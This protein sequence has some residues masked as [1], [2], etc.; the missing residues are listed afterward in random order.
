MNLPRPRL[1]GSRCLLPALLLALTSAAGQR[2][3]MPACAETTSPTQGANH[4]WVTTVEDQGEG[5]LRQA[6]EI[7]NARPGADLIRFD[8][9]L[10]PFATH[11]T[12]TLK[13]PLPTLADD[14]TI[15]GDQPERLWQST[16][17]TLSGGN[18]LPIFHVAPGVRVTLSSLTVAQGRAPCGGGVL[19]RGQLLV[20]GVTFLQNQAGESGGALCNQRG[21]AELINSTFFGNRADQVGGALANLGGKVI[22]TNCT[23]SE[24]AAP[25]G[26]GI[27]SHGQLLLRNTI[28]ANSVG[29]ADCRAE[30]IFHPASSHNLIEINQG[31]GQPI[32]STDPR[33]GPLGRYNGPTATLPLE[34]GSP[35]INLGDNAAAVDEKGWALRW[36][37][38]GNG[39]PRIVSGITD[40]GAFEHQLLPDLV[41]D[42]LEDSDLRS[43]TRAGRGDCSLRGAIT[44]ANAL[45]KKQTITFDPVIFSAPR[46]LVLERSLPAITTELNLDGLERGLVTIRGKPP[47]LRTQGPAIL[48]LFGVRVEALQ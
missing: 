29:D 46:T 25:R 37:Q 47:I 14:L 2:A 24:N 42:T 30:G 38:R 7:A 48:T 20:K 41:V 45:G 9:R 43:C 10:G 36:D 39:D 5:S 40:I 44:L 19:N 18:A 11:Q 23:F 13:G 28:A 4:F 8:G 34:S 22:V 35:A 12:I 1:V 26:A 16:G 6:I 21:A 31:C 33:L 27:Y 32:S 3:A 15:A 17:V